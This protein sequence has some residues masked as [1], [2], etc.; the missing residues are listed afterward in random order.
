[1]THTLYTSQ[2]PHPFE[3]NCPSRYSK[4]GCDQN[5]CQTLGETQGEM[6]NTWQRIEGP[7]K[8]F[9]MMMSLNEVCTRRIVEGL[10]DVSVWCFS[11]YLCGWSFVCS[12]CFPCFGCFLLPHKSEKLTR[13]VP[14]KWLLDFVA[15][16]IEHNLTFLVFIQKSFHLVILTTSQVIPLSAH[17]THHSMG[18]PLGW[19]GVCG[20]W[21]DGAQ[22]GLDKVRTFTYEIRSLE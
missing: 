8:M 13:L 11:F 10:F 20:A 5:P 7:G 9:R 17:V 4:V 18:Y 3:G 2:S 15:P 1:M 22:F 16:R 14:I 12:C 19:P 21:S 6:G